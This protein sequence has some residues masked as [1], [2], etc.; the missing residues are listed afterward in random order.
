MHAISAS[1]IRTDAQLMPTGRFI[2]DRHRT[3]PLV[4]RA[5][6]HTCSGPSRLWAAVDA[7]V[8]EYSAQHGC[9]VDA[10]LLRGWLAG[11]AAG[12]ES[13]NVR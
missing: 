13:L 5:W 7:D 6:A 4:C 12:I 3:L 11:R 10:E 9:T 8:R 2:R 1:C